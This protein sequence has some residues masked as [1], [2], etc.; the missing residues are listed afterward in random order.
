MDN[1]KERIMLMNEAAYPNNI[2][3]SEMVKFY[4][5]ADSAQLKK[6]E[7]IIKNS[8]WDAFKKMIKKV[9]GVKLQ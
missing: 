4:Q 3:F 1:F 8:D 9:L 5:V 2:G 6:M 7:T